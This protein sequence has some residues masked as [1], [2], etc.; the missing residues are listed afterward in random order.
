MV[1]NILQ[2]ASNFLHGIVLAVIAPIIVYVL[3]YKAN[4]EINPIDTI[5]SIFFSLFI[6][7]GINFA[8]LLIHRN[9]Q[10]TSLVASI[11]ILGLLYIWIHFLLALVTISITLVI[12]FIFHR[13]IQF[14]DIHF[15]FTIFSIILMGFYLFQFFSIIPHKT[16]NLSMGK[17]EVNLAE[18]MAE[19]DP[20]K[21]STPDIYYIILD[22]YGSSDMLRTIHNIDNSSFI[23]ALKEK[24]FFIAGES[25]ANY[26]RTILSL[27]S[28]LNMQYLDK[29]SAEMGESELWW[30]LSNPIKHSLVRDWLEKLGYTT[31]FFSTS[32][33]P[34][35]SRMEIIIFP[36]CH[37]HSTILNLFLLTQ[38][39][40]N[41]LMAWRNLGFQWL[42]GN[43]SEEP[44]CIRLKCCQ[45]LRKSTVLN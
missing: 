23:N 25:M 26:P 34:R 43:L 44:S 6:F 33:Y 37:I 11:L 13:K 30:P 22:N 36:L 9:P 35:I 20:T 19:I 27:A 40:L 2:L 42:H 45:R 7:L 18:N 16:Y 1:K 3:T 24:G 10:E 32:W 39:T 38:P 21:I 41:Y 5:S 12:L 8:L 4:I 31:I 29:I 14:T 28:S 15:A 17:S